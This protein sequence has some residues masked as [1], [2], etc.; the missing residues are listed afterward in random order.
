VPGITPV[1]AV[2]RN[3]ALNPLAGSAV[4]FVR[5]YHDVLAGSFPLITAN[6]SGPILELAGPRLAAC[7]APGGRLVTS[8]FREEY[9]PDLVER[10]FDLGL[11]PT[12]RARAMG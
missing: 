1:R 4:H 8:G 7:M 12:A 6:L 9:A 3:R 11:A 5:G 2:R 10:L